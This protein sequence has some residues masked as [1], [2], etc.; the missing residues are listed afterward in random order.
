MGKTATLRDVSH[1]IEHVEREGFFIDQNGERIAELTYEPTGDGSV[2][3][4]HT[5]V[6]DGLRGQG[7]ARRLLDALVAWARASNTKVTARCSY[8]VRELDRDPSLADVIST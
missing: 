7:I 8:I 2:V 5:W 1:T 6:S 3:A 4:D